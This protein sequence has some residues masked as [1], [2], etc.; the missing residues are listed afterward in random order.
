MTLSLKLEKKQ[1]KE[2]PLS[3]INQSTTDK[4]NK[5]VV[6]ARSPD[7]KKITAIALDQE[8]RA[9][10]YANAKAAKIVNKMSLTTSN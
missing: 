7:A 8:F 3:L 1:Q 10:L 9:Q 2:I 4:F 6:I 5:K